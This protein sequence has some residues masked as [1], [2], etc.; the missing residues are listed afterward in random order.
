MKDICLTA[1]IGSNNKGDEAIFIS[2]LKNLTDIQEISSVTVLTLNVNKT[3][4]LIRKYI[5]TQKP[6]LIKNVSSP[7][8]IPSIKESDYLIIGGGGLVQ[9]QTS[10]FNIPYHFWKAYLANLYN[11]K[12][13][14]HSL[15]VG[16]IKNPI[17]KYFV[18]NIFNK[19]SVIT[20]RDSV[21]KDLLKNLG[22][23]KRI[24]VTADPAISLNGKDYQES[25]KSDI[26]TTCGESLLGVSLRHWFDT[27][28]FLPVSIVKK[29]GLRSSK[30]SKRYQNFINE[31][32]LS[33]DYLSSTH[34]LK[35][36]FIPFWEE[37]DNKVHRD[38][39][40]RMNTTNFQVIEDKDPIQTLNLVGKCD[41]YLGMRL[42]SLIF[43]FTK[44]VPFV[45]INYAPKVEN[46]LEILFDAEAN[47]YYIDPDD[48]SKTLIHKMEQVLERRGLLINIINKLEHNQDIIKKREGH[49]YELIKDE[50]NEL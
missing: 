35:I 3:N 47:R 11:T 22:V 36:V 44:N 30:D 21:S 18:K 45:A 6:L 15:G 49:N 17:S 12:L 43:S 25:N 26:S 14:F 28:K 46:F 13:I 9:D 4:E 38:V 20:V 37:R 5:H 2:T 1:F 42:H 50:L 19:A 48:S 16:P 31:I 29:L 23:T 27:Y 41:Y 7:S 8:A 39:I 34:N 33:L 10:I 40:E 32:A 24:E